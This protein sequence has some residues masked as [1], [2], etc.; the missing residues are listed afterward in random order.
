MEETLKKIFA[1]RM[2]ITI[3]KI[4]DTL[5]G[6]IYEILSCSKELDSETISELRWW[7]EVEK[8]VE[9]TANTF[10]SYITAEATG[11]STPTELGWERPSINTI[12]RV[13]PERVVTIRYR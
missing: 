12:K 2:G 4:D 3:D 13:Y 11:D 6:D 10:V 5:A 7:N 8:V 1:D 9:L